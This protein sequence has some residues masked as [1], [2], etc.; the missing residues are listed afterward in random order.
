[1]T[2]VQCAAVAALL[3]LATVGCSRNAAPPANSDVL[4]WPVTQLADAAASAKQFKTV[5]ATGTAPDEKQR[6]RYAEGMYIVTEIHPNSEDAAD[7]RVKVLDGNSAERGEVTWTVIREA[8]KW[9][10]KSAPLP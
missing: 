10:L 9:K 3:S 2:G 7:L 4:A 6:K 1:M 5:F 8:G